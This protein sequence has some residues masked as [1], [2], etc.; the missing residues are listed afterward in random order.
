MKEYQI[1]EIK[2]IKINGRTTMTQGTLNLFWTGSGF[3]LNAK[4]S[5]LWIEIESGYDLHEPW[6]AVTVNGAPTTRQMAYAGTSKICLFRNMNPE[7]VKHVQFFKE[8]QAMNEDNGHFLRVNKIFFDGDF[9][10]V[11]EKPYKFEFIGDSITSGEG[12]IGAKKELDWISMF[13]NSVHHY[14][15]LTSQAMDADYRIVSE[16]GWGILTG[17]D[18]DPRHALPKYYTQVCGILN[19]EQNEQMGALEEHDFTSWQPD[20]VVINLGTNDESAFHQPEFTVPETGE[21]YKQHLNPDGSHNKEDARRVEDAVTA[22]L[23]VVRAKNPKAKIVWVYGMLGYMLTGQ[24]TNGIYR[25]QE[26]TGDMQVYFRQLPKADAETVGSRE[27]PGVK[28][29]ELAAKVLTEILKEIL[30]E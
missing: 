11:L 22:F 30:S 20:V 8:V 18:N 6:F 13:F 27:H 19:G 23:E 3:E 12:T 24:I 29:H 25:Y 26:K 16:S 5:E 7:E 10:P 9:L 4:G 14:A 17:W 2:N 21:N 1:N 15:Y 28:C